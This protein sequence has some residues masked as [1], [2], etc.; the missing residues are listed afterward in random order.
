MTSVKYLTIGST[1][2]IVQYL[3]GMCKDLEFCLPAVLLSQ[4]TAADPSSWLHGLENFIQEL[5]GISG[6]C[7]S[8]VVG[9]Y[10]R[11]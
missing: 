6:M 10:S 3:I 2:K 11:L 1:L 8:G 7:P 5:F 4:G 9:G